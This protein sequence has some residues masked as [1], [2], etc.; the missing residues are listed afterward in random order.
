MI[1]RYSPLLICFLV[2]LVSFTCKT[3]PPPVPEPEPEPVLENTE[4]EPFP[5]DFNYDYGYDAWNFD[6]NAEV[7]PAPTEPGGGY[8]YPLDEP[9]YYDAQPELSLPP[10]APEEGII[11]DLIEPEPEPEPEEI[12]SVEPPPEETVAEALSAPVEPGAPPVEAVAEAPPVEPAVAETEE[13]L[14]AEVVTEAPAAEPPSPES[15]LPPGPPPE[16]Q[17]FLRPAEPLPPPQ[18]VREVPPMPTVPEPPARL[19]PNA[20]AL[21]LVPVPP[22]RPLEEETYSRIVRALKGQIIEIPYRGTGWVYLGETSARPGIVYNSRRL[23]GEG[24]SFV[25]RAEEAGSY[26]LKFYRQDFVRD[27]IINDH[28]QVIVEEAP[29]TAVPAGVPAERVT[30]LPRWPEPASSTAHISGVQGRSE[31]QAAPQSGAATGPPAQPVTVSGR[32]DAPP[33]VSSQGGP[34]DEGIAPVGTSLLNRPGE[35]SVLPPTGPEL[36]GE[37]LPEEYL[38]RAREESAAGHVQ[39]ALAI[40]KQFGNRFPQGSDEAWWLLGQLYEANSPYRN[41]RLSMDYYRRLI[42]EYPQ[43]QRYGDARRRIAYLERYYFNI[44]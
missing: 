6:E 19:P 28:V 41:I 42:R 26:E 32:P 16:P 25:F 12:P 39:E 20:P 23:E 34:A 31:A 11:A 44:Q 4:P 5:E 22:S 9:F 43:S 7:E 14:P 30:A 36:S 35:A 1:C 18:P 13:A 3:T 17:R 27:Y 33:V 8:D 21:G 24:I 37:T 29:E 38:R 15:V 40:L 10:A 2:F